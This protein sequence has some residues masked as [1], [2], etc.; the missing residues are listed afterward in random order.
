MIKLLPVRGTLTAGRDENDGMASKNAKAYDSIRKTKCLAIH[1]VPL[2]LEKKQ[3]STS[4]MLA[5]VSPVKI[6]LIF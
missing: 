2:L 3:S 6:V 4:V 5:A 1:V